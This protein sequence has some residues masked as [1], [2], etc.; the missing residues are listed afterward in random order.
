MLFFKALRIQ[1]LSDYCTNGLIWTTWPSG[2]DSFL[3]LVAFGFCNGNL[4]YKNVKKDNHAKLIVYGL[5][6]KLVQKVVVYTI[7][8]ILEPSRT[9]KNRKTKKKTVKI[10][11]SVMW[12]KLIHLC[13]PWLKVKQLKIPSKGIQKLP[14]YTV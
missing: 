12:S 2:P 10:S 14:L 7:F 8:H 13:H 11:K 4:H 9:L 5:L 1:F 3:I 6:W